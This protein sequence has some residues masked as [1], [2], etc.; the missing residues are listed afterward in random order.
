MYFH[1]VTCQLMHYSYFV[2]NLKAIN[3]V[4]NAG[5]QKRVSVSK[6]LPLPVS[7]VSVKNGWKLVVVQLDVYR[8]FS[9]CAERDEQLRVSRCF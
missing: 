6:K 2:A 7:S 1:D 9:V 8:N 3:W 4:C 5:S